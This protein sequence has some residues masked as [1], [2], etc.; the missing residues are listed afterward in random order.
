MRCEFTS[1]RY[2]LRGKV[3]AEY[4]TWLICTTNADESCT[5]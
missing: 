2:K 3:D 4:D 5:A 1:H